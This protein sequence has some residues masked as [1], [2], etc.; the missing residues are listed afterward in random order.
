MISPDAPIERVEDDK[1]GRAPFA[2]ALATAILNTTGT[3]S[4]VVGIHGKWGTGKSSVLNLCVEELR[5]QTQNTE[6]RAEILRFNPWN[7]ADQNQLV[8]QFFRQFTAHLRKV[9]ARGLGKIKNLVEALDAY[10]TALAPPEAVPYAKLPWFGFRVGIGMARKALGLGADLESL[11]NSISQELKQLKHKTV[12][13]ID[14]IDRLAAGEIRQVFQLVKVSAR[15]PSVIYVLAF[16]RGAVVSALE[17]L[18]VDSG[19]DY[20]E[21]IVQV[22]FDLPPVSESMLTTIISEALQE[23]FTRFPSARFD[24]HRFGNMFHA[25]FRQRFESLRDVRRFL[26]GL[27][28]S[29]GM[30][31][32]EL[33]GVD[34]I[35][36]EALR[37]FYPAVYEAVR[38]NKRLFAGEVDNLTQQRGSAAFRDEVEKVLSGTGALAEVKD[39]LIEL[40]PKLGFAYANTAY[41]ADWEAEWEKDFRVGSS[42]YFDFYFRLA[43]PTDE[44]SAAEIDRSMDAASDAA[45]FRESLLSYVQ[46]RR[47]LNGISSIRHRL[48][49]VP[50][51]FLPNILAS[52]LDIGDIV[53]QTGSPL[54]GDIPEY[55]HVRWAI[56]DVLDRLP[57]ETRFP[58]LLKAFENCSALGTMVNIVALLQ[59]IKEKQQDK[60]PELSEDTL[61]QLKSTVVERIRR[62]SHEE[63]FFNNESLPS[64]LWAW[65]NWGNSAEAEAY[66]RGL[67]ERP[68]RLAGFLDKFVSQVHSA[69]LSD[70][71]VTTT[72]MLACR[73][74]AEWVD[75]NQLLHTVRHLDSSALSK[76]QSDILAFIKQALE[77][78]QKSG[79]TPAQF[80]NR[81]RLQGLE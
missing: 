14:D 70:R 79:L 7:F 5:K 59:E 50:P 27:E 19:Q 78:F 71:V 41:S 54:F 46:S 44:V 18:G 15:F 42:R 74:L 8:L 69:G 29:C 68:E 12:V 3:E 80:D 17:K 21:K 32:R 37:V 9:D 67:L 51:Q 81:Q 36:L 40:F 66:V 20:L 2:R 30:I 63:A 24:N 64:I 26:N 33:N 22:S 45:A 65:K 61:R 23:L 55:W 47:V 4:F 57:V 25:G 77:Q 72:N 35:G 34:L 60:Y 28:F 38:N 73:A 16:E 1:L 58:T 53:K 56:F 13:I 11:Y 10:A 48:A 75:L 76:H 49:D 52:L 43:I 31:A 39:L 6:Q 62:L